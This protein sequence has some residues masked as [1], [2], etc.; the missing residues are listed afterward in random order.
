MTIAG[1]DH[2]WCHI[3]N[4]LAPLCKHFVVTCFLFC[5]T[6]ELK[7]LVVVG[8]RAGAVSMRAFMINSACFDEL[9]LRCRIDAGPI[10]VQC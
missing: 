3:G 9:I 4:E 6:H 5:D 10:D 1:G 2:E 8:A 7:R